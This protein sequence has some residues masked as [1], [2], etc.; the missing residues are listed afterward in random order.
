M[1]VCIISLY[2]K[3]FFCLITTCVSLIQF[4]NPDQELKDHAY[5]SEISDVVV[6]AQLEIKICKRKQDHFFHLLSEGE[7]QI[8]SN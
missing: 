4:L 6:Q 3:R 7:T 2:H 5:G 8:K 1:V